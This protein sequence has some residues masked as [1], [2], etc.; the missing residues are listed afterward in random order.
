MFLF[1]TIVFK[2]IAANISMSV[3]TMR[4]ASKAPLESQRA[5]TAQRESADLENAHAIHT[6]R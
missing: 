6:L 3:N 5:H 4:K 2:A 1:L